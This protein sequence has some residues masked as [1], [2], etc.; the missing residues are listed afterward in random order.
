MFSLAMPGWESALSIAGVALYAREALRAASD[1]Q[2]E[3]SAEYG[4]L[5]CRG[6]SA[7]CDCGDGP[8]HGCYMIADVEAAVG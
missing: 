1:L 4:V 2:G 7:C 3:G 5:Q 8:C 6:L